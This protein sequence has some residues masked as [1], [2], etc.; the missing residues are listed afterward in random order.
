MAAVYL[1]LVAAAN[2][3][4]IAE[5]VQLLRA[6]RDAP[7]VTP[8]GPLTSLLRAPLAKVTHPWQIYAIGVGFGVGFDTA[9]TMALLILTAAS[10]AGLGSANA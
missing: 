5:S 3:P 4:R 7:L 1:A 10:A 8:G 9:S 6:G 2:L